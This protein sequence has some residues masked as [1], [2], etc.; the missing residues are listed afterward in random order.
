MKKKRIST[1]LGILLAIL[2]LGALAGTGYVVLSRVAEQKGT[3]ILP[4]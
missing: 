3:A 2:V 4:R 1:F